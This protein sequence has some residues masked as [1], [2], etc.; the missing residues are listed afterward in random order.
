M[1]GGKKKVARTETNLLLKAA[2]LFRYV[3]PFCY[4]QALKG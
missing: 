2:G 3:W 1:P 4:Y